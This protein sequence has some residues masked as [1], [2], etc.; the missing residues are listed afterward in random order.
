MSVMTGAI[1]IATLTDATP[2]AVS[3][4]NKPLPSTIWLH[5]LATTGRKL[6]FSVDNGVLYEECV[7]AKDTLVGATNVKRAILSSGVTHVRYTGAAADTYGI[8]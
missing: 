5:S 7:Y 1:L 3:M 4:V 2:V 8:C 6:E